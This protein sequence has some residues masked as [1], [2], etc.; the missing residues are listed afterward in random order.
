MKRLVFF[1]LIFITGFCAAQTRQSDFSQRGA[2][3]QEIKQLDGLYAAHPSL[4]IG[5]RAIVTNPENEITIEVTVIGRIMASTDRIIDLSPDAIWALDIS[6]GGEVIVSIHNQQILREP[7]PPEVVYMPKPEPVIVPAPEPVAVTP[8]P[9]AEVGTQP[10]NITI[11]SYI[12][13]PDN[14]PLAQKPEDMEYLEWLA[15]MILE[16]REGRKVRDSGGVAVLR[17]PENTVF[18]PEPPAPAPV[19]AQPVP[20]PVNNIRVMPGLPDPNTGKL[21]RLQVGAYS[22][23]RTAYDICRTMLSG[24]FNAV[25]ERLGSMYRVFATD[26][27]AAVV[28]YAAKR[29]ESMGFEE[30]WVHD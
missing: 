2:V 25:Y 10:V 28:Y 15:M 23:E 19:V 9:P 8:K 21:Y 5:S 14:L 3:T 20:P 29:L 24:G 11:Y 26:V 27:P 17:E 18:R 6:P 13:S 4:P 16:S 22:S 1:G 30:V 12:V 7:P